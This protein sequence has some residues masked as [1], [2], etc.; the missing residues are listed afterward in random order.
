MANTTLVGFS[1][2]A[3]QKDKNEWHEMKDPH[4]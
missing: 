1:S 3:G 2:N 4:G